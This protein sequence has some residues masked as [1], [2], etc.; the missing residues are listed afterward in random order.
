[1]SLLTRGELLFIIA[2]YKSGGDEPQPVVGHF[3]WRK[4]NGETDLKRSAFC[5]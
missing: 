4:A 5:L 2:L 3:G 1:V